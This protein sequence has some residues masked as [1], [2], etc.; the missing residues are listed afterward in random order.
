MSTPEAIDAC[1]RE[2]LE[3]QEK[4][5]KDKDESKSGSAS[6]KISGH[7]ANL[8]DAED[9]EKCVNIGNFDKF[10]ECLTKLHNSQKG[11]GKETSVDFTS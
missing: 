1:F 8:A 4:K 2:E 11:K 7:L 10:Q 6:G 5:K 9:I 3:V